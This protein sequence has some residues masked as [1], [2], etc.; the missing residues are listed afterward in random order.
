MKQIEFLSWSVPGS[1]AWFLVLQIRS[2][3]F[4]TVFRSEPIDF[5]SKTGAILASICH[6]FGLGPSS[7]G[8][9]TNLKV[10]TNK[11]AWIHWS[12]DLEP[13]SKVTLSF[14]TC[15]SIFYLGCTHKYLCTS[16]FF[17]FLLLSIL[18]FVNFVDFFHFMCIFSQIH[19]S[20]RNF[21]NFFKFSL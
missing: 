7:K 20:K 19:T 3:P 2:S 9:G 17:P 15:F 14:T 8:V 6:V 1:L 13:S 4:S 5:P 21:P 16:V 11:I 12:L 18:R 10:S